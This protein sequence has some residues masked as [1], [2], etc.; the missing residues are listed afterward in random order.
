MTNTFCS[1]VLSTG[2]RQYWEIIQ[3]LELFHKLQRACV[4]TE[5]TLQ[6]LVILDSWVTATCVTDKLS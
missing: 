6:H 2:F 5:C 3:Q 4:Y 1:T